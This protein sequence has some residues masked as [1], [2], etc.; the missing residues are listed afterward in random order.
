MTPQQLMD[1]C[2]SSPTNTVNLYESTKFQTSFSGTT[3]VSPTG[4]TVVLGQGVSFELDTITMH[5][6]GPLVVQ[7]PRGGKVSVDKATLSAPS[8]TLALTGSEGQF[9]LNEG[10]VAATQ[11]DLSIAFGSKGLMEVKNSGAWYQPRLSA[12]GALRINSS[13]FFSGTIVQ[14]GVQGATGIHITLGGSD[15][16]MKVEN[17]DMLVS[18][19]AP[20][21]GTYT[22]GPF[23]VRSGA[24][25][26]SFEMI[27]VNLME[28][29]RDVTIDFGGF[30]SKVGL[31]SVRSQTGSQR[32]AFTARGFGSEVK[33][34]DAL[35][36]A[37]PEVVVEAGISGNVFIGGSTSSIRATQSIRVRAANQGS[38]FVQPGAVSAPS[39]QLCL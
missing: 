2:V 26:V 31:K 23:A 19:G 33:I 17:T 11:G 6:G 9:Q 7:A 12:R 13:H 38:C 15:S 21:G 5:F 22:A 32:I 36:Y 20:N 27:N 30:A 18:S 37:N 8:I 4:C 3:F 14:S 24:A 39:Q 35:F 1:A 10:R 16:S 29:S 34:E 25:N 28:A